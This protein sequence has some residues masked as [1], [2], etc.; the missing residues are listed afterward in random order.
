MRPTKFEIEA[1]IR[2]AIRAALPPE[3]PVQWPNAP[4]T[5]P[6]PE[7]GTLW[8]RV[9][10]V[11]GETERREL[12]PEGMNLII[13]VVIL[14]VF[15]PTESG[16]DALSDMMDNV[17]AALDSTTTPV[18]VLFR[19]AGPDSLGNQV[20]DSG[21]YQENMNCPFEVQVFIKEAS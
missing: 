6:D 12:G 19:E 8:V 3:T 20:T 4:F 11:Y 15:V 2:E 18:G 1:D 14:S 7:E 13:G 10:I 17:I 21:W 9:A 16:T 5:I